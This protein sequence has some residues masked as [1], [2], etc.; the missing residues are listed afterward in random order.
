MVLQCSIFRTDEQQCCITCDRVKH[1]KHVDE[2]RQNCKKLSFE[3]GRYQKNKNNDNEEY[4]EKPY[5][6]KKQMEEEYIVYISLVHALVLWT[7]EPMDI[8]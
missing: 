6:F 8:K 3:I 1:I 7:E 4:R 2:E 5:D